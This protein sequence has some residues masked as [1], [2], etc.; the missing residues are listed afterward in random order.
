M[1]PWRLQSVNFVFSVPSCHFHFSSNYS[2]KHYFLYEILCINYPL[3]ILPWDVIRRRNHPSSGVIF[4]C[5]SFHCLHSTLSSSS[6][7]IPIQGGCFHLSVAGT[8]P[9]LC[10][11]PALHILFP[12]P[13]TVFSRHRRGGFSWLLCHPAGTSTDNLPSEKFFPLAHLGGL[14]PTSLFSIPE[15]GSLLWLWEEEKVEF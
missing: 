15:P 5:P 8:C 9:V 3:D 6:H 2:M 12:Q 7:A 11:L 10:C 4:I 1:T 14:S 13:G